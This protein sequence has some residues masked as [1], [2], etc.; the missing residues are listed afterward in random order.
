M[1]HSKLNPVTMN[2]STMSRSLTPIEQTTN[3]SAVKS[4]YF[5][6]NT[7][8]NSSMNNANNQTQASNNVLLNQT[9]YNSQGG[10]GHRAHD[11]SYLHPNTSSAMM[12]YQTGLN[13]SVLTN[14][15]SSYLNTNVGNNVSQ[16]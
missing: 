15:K 13:N 10:I 1:P 2:Y 3:S 4:G 8:I 5:Q 14:E 6:P 12:H 16:N 9:H 11:V 7:N